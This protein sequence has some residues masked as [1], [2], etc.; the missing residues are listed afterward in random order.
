MP[1]PAPEIEP[2]VEEKPETDLTPV[3]V[4]TPFGTHIEVEEK[5]VDTKTTEPTKIEDVEKPESDP[6]DT[7]PISEP[8]NDNVNIVIMNEND[9]FLS[10]IPEEGVNGYPKKIIKALIYSGLGITAVAAIIGVPWLIYK[11]V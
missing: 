5:P 11:Y 7:E 1:D 9:E 3:L 8:A 4:V 6:K 2:K 10:K